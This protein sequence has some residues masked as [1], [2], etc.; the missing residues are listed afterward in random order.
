MNWRILILVLVALSV[1]APF[2]AT[3]FCA[4]ASCCAQMQSCCNHCACPQRQSCRVT[5]P[6]TI[7]QQIV[8]NAAQVSPRILLELFTLFPPR[9]DVLESSHDRLSWPP[10]SPPQSAQHQQAVLCLW[11]I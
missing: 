10:E 9:L 7:D 6:V 11:L 8:A 2:E 5:K 4:K 3:S 1:Y